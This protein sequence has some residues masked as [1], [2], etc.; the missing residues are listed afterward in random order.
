MVALKTRP[1]EGGNMEEVVRNITNM[2]ESKKTKE[3]EK[4]QEFFIRLCSDLGIHQQTL[5]SS[6]R[7]CT[8]MRLDVFM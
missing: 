2:W 4:K 1:G 7:T 5:T 3:G 6:S 8:V